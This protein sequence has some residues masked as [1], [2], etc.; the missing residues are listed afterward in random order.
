MLTTR[1][2][3]IPFFLSILSVSSRST[4]TGFT[5][6]TGIKSESRVQVANNFGRTSPRFHSNLDGLETEILIEE[7]VLIR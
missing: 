3:S 2:I 7:V 1:S 6:P 5:G 4:P